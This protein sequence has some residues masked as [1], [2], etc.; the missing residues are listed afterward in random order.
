MGQP[1][2][3]QVTGTECNTR[4]ALQRFPSTAVAGTECANRPSDLRAGGGRGLHG[5]GVE[6]AG[7]PVRALVEW[8]RESARGSGAE[9]YGGCGGRGRPWT[10]A[11]L[12]PRGA[13]PGCSGS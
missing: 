3:F 2:E 12:H 9:P 5:G 6:D 7:L 1:C 10:P 13:P 11:R 8:A 4:H